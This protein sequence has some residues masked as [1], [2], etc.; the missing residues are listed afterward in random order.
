VTWS[1]KFKAPSL[2]KT[3]LR[4]EKTSHNWEKI[5]AIHISNEGI[6]TII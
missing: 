5:L 3:L 2:L 6:I 1:S 4:N